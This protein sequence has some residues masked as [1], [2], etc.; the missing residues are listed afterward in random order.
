VGFIVLIKKTFD[1][2]NTQQNV[3]KSNVWHV[4]YPEDGGS[5]LLRNV[6][7]TYPTIQ[8]HISEACENT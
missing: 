3:R 8:R 5:N 6:N 2:V 7:T 1:I 4:A